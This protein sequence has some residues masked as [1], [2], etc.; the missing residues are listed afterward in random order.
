MGV[1]V[2]GEMIGSEAAST[3]CVYGGLKQRELLEKWY[4]GRWVNEG[5]GL[6]TVVVCVSV[7]RFHLCHNDQDPP[8]SFQGQHDDY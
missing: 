4:L 7:C 1:R 8:P 3:S 2:G 6:N 5:C